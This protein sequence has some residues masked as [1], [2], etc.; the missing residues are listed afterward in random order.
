MENPVLIFPVLFLLDV[1]F[2]Q[3]PHVDL[4]RNKASLYIYVERGLPKST[5]DIALSNIFA[6]GPLAPST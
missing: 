5:R 1:S 3:G 4:T 6:L 2:E